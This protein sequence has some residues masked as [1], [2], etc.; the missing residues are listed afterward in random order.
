MALDT[1]TQVRYRH[2]V[3]GLDRLTDEISSLVSDFP[4]P[5]K[6][7]GEDGEQVLFITERLID[8]IAVMRDAQT[9]RIEAQVSRRMTA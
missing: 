8:V 7:T 6:A 4:S 9:R 3:D 5:D 1:R 2:S